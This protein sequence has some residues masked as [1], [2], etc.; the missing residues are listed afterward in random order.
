[1]ERLFEKLRKNDKIPMHMPGHKRNGKK[2]S[3]LRD[4]S[5]IDITEIEGFDNLHS[6][7]GILKKSMEEA[8]KLR[9]ADRAFYLI[10]GSTCGI[11]AVICAAVK[12]DD[13]VI[14]ARN[15]HKSVYNGVNLA[16]AKPV[17][18]YP[19]NSSKYGIF[20]SINPSDIEQKIKENPDAKLIIITSP[21]YEGVISDIEKICKIA[22]KRNIPVLVDAAH[23]AHLGFGNF[24]KDAIKLGADAAVESLHKTLPSLTQTAIC[25]VSGSLI[26]KDAVSEKLAV[27]ETSSPSY[28]LLS[29]IDGCVN[30]LKMHGKAI[31]G[32]WEEI[33][34][35]FYNDVAVL[36]N[37]EILT[38]GDNEFFDIDKSKIVLFPKNQSG[39]ELAEGLRK[40]G[41][42]PEMTAPDYVICM[43]GAGETRKNLKKLA[44]ALTKIDKGKVCIN[45]I[46]RL[47]AEK[48]NAC[49]EKGEFCKIEKAVGRISAGYL[50][51][52]P[53]EVPILVP[54]EEI[55]EDTVSKICKYKRNG[56]SLFGDISGDKIPV[57]KTK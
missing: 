31:F 11:L 9:G 19:E 48:G 42:E 18:V 44:K 4:F 12:K 53:P 2:F 25:Y 47:S 41:I 27:F 34:G 17:F 7:N 33:L 35:E 15:C 49:F 23:G 39:A 43:T 14:M 13:T 20:G 56:L 21:T 24:P 16:G 8:A 54:D 46:N 55:T 51:A 38:N 50:W 22:H 36:K 3:Y 29:S 52:Y 45:G 40:C 10:N 30:E 1:M 32:E 6:A 37:I 5:G 28:I 26:D 57:K